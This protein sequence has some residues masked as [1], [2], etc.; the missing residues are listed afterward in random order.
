MK[1]LI[2]LIVLLIGSISYPQQEE[3]DRGTVKYL[4]RQINSLTFK[5][6]KDNQS[7]AFVGKEQGI[8]VYWHRIIESDKITYKQVMEQSGMYAE[9]HVIIT[10]LR[11]NNAIGSHAVQL[12]YK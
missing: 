9:G 10:D 4:L 6:L 3:T 2:V 12:R 8:S 7:Y 11:G 5:K 1:K